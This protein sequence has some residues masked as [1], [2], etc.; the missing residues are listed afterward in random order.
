[1]SFSQEWEDI[2][3]RGEQMVHWPWSDLISLVHRFRATEGTVYELGCGPGANYPF[4]DSLGMVYWGV[5]GSETAVNAL[6]AAAP[7]LR[8]RVHVGDFTKESLG[9]NIADLVVDRAAVVHNPIKAMSQAI[10]N[11][12]GLLKP[13][14][15]Y[16]GVDWFSMSHEDKRQFQNVGV[17]TRMTRPLIEMLFEGFEIVYLEHKVWHRMIPARMPCAAFDIVA[18]KPGGVS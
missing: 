4:F 6:L 8:G 5:D 12:R 17:T 7:E 1:M 2:Y 16:I 13:G 10:N 11:A 3:Q 18:R 15:L 14:G 9:E